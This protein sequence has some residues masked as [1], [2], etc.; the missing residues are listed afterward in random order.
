MNAVTQARAALD[1]LAEA[2]VS[3][4]ADR[5]LAHELALSA[6][7]TDLS[8]Y[9]ASAT[10]PS[11]FGEALKLR[12]DL[13]SVRASLNRCLALGGTAAALAAVLCPSPTGYSSSGIVT[14]SP[15]SASF[16]TYASGI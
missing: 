1:A 7:A 13:F 12:A 10:R 11:S 8:L 3:G 14:T 9:A 16:S 2:L 6:A 15:V 5:V 4:D